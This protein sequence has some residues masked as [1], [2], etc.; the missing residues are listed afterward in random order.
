[1]ASLFNTLSIGYSGLNAAQVGINTTGHNISNAEVKGYTRERV[2]QSAQTPL[3]TGSGNIGNGTKVQD[4]A[5]VFDNF[6]FNRY[7]S[8]SSNKEYTDFTQ[9]SLE[10]LSTYF[11]EIDG[12][13]IKADL[14][15]YYNMWQTFADNPNNSAIKVALAKQTETLSQH[16]NQ[17]QSQVKHLQSTLNSQLS[18]DIDQV[19]SLA[20]QLADLNGAIDTAESGNVYIASDLR[21][22]RNVL[23][24]SLARLIGS[25]VDQGQIQANIQID[26]NSNTRTESYTLNINGF[27]IVDGKTFHP[28]SIENKD[29][30]DGLYSL[31][32]KR[33]DGTLIPMEESI[34]SGKIGAI[35]DLRGGTIDTTTGVPTDGTVQKVVAQLDAFAKGLIEATNNLYAA[36]STTRMQS[37]PQT[38]GETDSLLSSNLNIHQGT[39]DLVVYDINGNEVARRGINIDAAT[40]I[41]SSNNTNPN[42]IEAQID[43]KID[44][45]GDGNANDNINNFLS[46]NYQ[47]SADGITRL[48]LGIKPSPESQ[49]YTF[50]LEDKL[51]TTD[52]SSGT[53]F[54]GALGLGRYFDGDNASNINLT[55]SIA[56]NSSNLHAGYSNTNGDSRVAL[57]IV[58]QQFES[59]NFKIGEES[60]DSTIYG[61]FDTTATFVG[62]S[63]NAAITKN[64]TTTTQFNA[65]KLEYDSVSKVNIDEELTNLIKYQTSYGA[66]AK[67]ITAV[68]QMMQTL[69]GIKQ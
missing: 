36:S 49:G 55:T 64:E 42:S 63:T 44:D 60:Y 30:K 66:S 61:M 11:P 26:S 53:N 62:I 14:A 17:T 23:E 47:Q 29:N 9:Q 12:V 19:N 54:A 68:D 46:Y 25:K 50:S 51:K 3:F 35:L 52:F 32:Y 10:E 28:I 59:Y 37:N 7:T 45:N 40:S 18:V 43:A 22:Q 57:S 39:F 6:V 69:L 41:G 4:I 2:I 1:M 15:N 67:V 16:I 24:H 8:V 27:N 34:N 13:G 56:N 48:E 58:Q 20:S 21:D 65:V 33:Q 31:S 38:L 5:R